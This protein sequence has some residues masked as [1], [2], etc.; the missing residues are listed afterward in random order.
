MTDPWEFKIIFSHEFL[1]PEHQRLRLAKVKKNRGCVDLSEPVIVGKPIEVRLVSLFSSKI[2]RD[3]TLALNKPERH[4]VIAITQAEAEEPEEKEV[5]EPQ[6]AAT[7]L[8]MGF[9]QIEQVLFDQH[10]QKLQPNTI[11]STCSAMTYHRVGV[12][13]RS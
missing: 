11:T 13:L 1:F 5:K 10:L 6:V 2:Q 9:H 12:P 8:S 4:D 7:V 3:F